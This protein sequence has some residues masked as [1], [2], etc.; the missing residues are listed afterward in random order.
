M[1]P[2]LN[3]TPPY[4]KNLDTCAN[5]TPFYYSFFLY[6]IIKPNKNRPK[7]TL[8]RLQCHIAVYSIY[9]YRHLAIIRFHLRSERF[10]DIDK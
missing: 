8:Y 10:R 9:I 5:L 1:K 4:L 7:E 6:S 2:E 3:N